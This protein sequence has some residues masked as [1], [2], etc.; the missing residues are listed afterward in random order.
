MTVRQVLAEL[1]SA[2]LISRQ[3]GRGTF[4]REPGRLTLLV[5]VRSADQERLVGQV[6]SAGYAVVS[7][8]GSAE[9]LERLAADASIGLLFTDLADLD[10]VRTVH[11]RWP[12]VTLVAL[13]ASAA[14]L[15]PLQ[16]APE[17]PTLILPLPP[18]AHQLD[19]VLRL[20]RASSRGPAD[21]TRELLEFQSQLLGAV[22]H[23]IVATGPHG[24]IIYWNAAAER[25]YGWRA[26]EVLGRNVGDVLV[27]PVL[28]ERGTEIMDRLRR[29]E[30]WTGEFPVLRRDGSEVPVLVTDSPVT[31]AQG[32]LVGTIGVAVDISERKQADSDRLERLRLEAGLA[33]DPDA[34]GG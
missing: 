26:A 29:G 8:P 23:A 11:Q 34:P 4:V 5:V 2:G 24:N 20:G 32:R 1:E 25:L 19:Q 30:T 10:L 27:A 7:V 31:D 14:E 17:C 28:R 12:A 21:A 15:A 18:H 6:A 16:H 9:A 3:L 13:L 33:A 22:Q